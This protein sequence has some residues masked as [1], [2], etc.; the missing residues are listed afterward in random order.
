MGGKNVR[1]IYYGSG[2]LNIAEQLYGAP[3]AEMRAVEYFEENT[4]PS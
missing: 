4:I 2:V 3:K 1:P